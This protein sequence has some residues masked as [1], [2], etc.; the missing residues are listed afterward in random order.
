MIEVPWHDGERIA[1]R[2]AGTAERMEEIGPKVVRDFMPDQHRQ[3]F[4]QLPF[5]VVGSRDQEQRPWASI[6][7]GLRGFAHIPAGWRSKPIPC[8]EIR[9][10]KRCKPARRSAFSASSCRPGVATA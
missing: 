10:V 4:E 3:F 6:V 7:A 9:W 5:V 1:Q 2:R 8:P